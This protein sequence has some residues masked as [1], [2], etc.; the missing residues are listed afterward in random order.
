M[1][2]PILV[3]LI[4]T[5]TVSCSSGT[6]AQRQRTLID[7]SGPRPDWVSGSKVVLEDEKNL[8]FRSQAT[9]RGD[10]RLGSCMDLSR[11]QAQE[12]VLTEIQT[13]VR[14]ALSQAQTNPSEAAELLLTR[15]L[16]SDFQ[17][18]LRG[19]RTTDEYF[20]RFQIAENERIECF[21]LNQIKRSDFERL[22]Q[23]VIN[24]VVAADPAVKAALSDQQ[25]K[26][27]KGE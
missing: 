26:F 18:K 17:G 2:Y 24:R 25:A 8:N 3:S 14:G 4:T 9:I 22:K 19:L 5:L 1:K 12:R 10:E 7:S 6:I 16:S 23:E 11:M 15:S 13:E 20:E 27:F 21:T